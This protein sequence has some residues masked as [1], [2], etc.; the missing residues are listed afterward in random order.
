MNERQRTILSRLAE[1]AAARIETGSANALLARRLLNE[2]SLTV[3]TNDV[4]ITRTFKNSEVNLVL[5][6]VDGIS[7]ETS[8]TC[9]DM[10]RA[11]VSSRAVSKSENTFIITD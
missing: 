6:G 11:D 7:P 2:S 3:V 1:Q 10:L 4:F 9:S 5:L 8:V